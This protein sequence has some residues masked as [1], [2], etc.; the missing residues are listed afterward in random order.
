MSNHT[1][2]PWVLKNETAE[3]IDLESTNEALSINGGAIIARFYGIQRK[4]NAAFI[5]RA[6][7][8]HD[9]LVKA[10][11][12]AHSALHEVD[13]LIGHLPARDLG[14]L[15]NVSATISHHKKMIVEALAK[16]REEA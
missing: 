1:N 14:P 11:G 10:L 7:N 12:H 3:T 4:T 6:C 2:L 9:E 8:A 15:L 5:V 13:G 16:A